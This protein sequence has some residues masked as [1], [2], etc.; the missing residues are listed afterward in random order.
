MKKLLITITLLFLYCNVQAEEKTPVSPSYL[1][2]KNQ[3]TL[4]DFH[5]PLLKREVRDNFGDTISVPTKL[6]PKGYLSLGFGGW[7]DHDTKGKPNANNEVNTTLDLTYHPYGREENFLGGRPFIGFG[8]IF[9]NSRFGQTD[10]VSI[11]NEW[12]L[13]NGKYLGFSLG[14]GFTHLRYEDAVAKIGKKKF[15]EGTLPLVYASLD[16]QEVPISIRVI[17]LGK[18][19]V[20]CYLLLNF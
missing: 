18:D 8:R 14:A 6:K 9:K 13:I 3:L 5:V 7:S 16:F 12:S 1:L 2:A 20:F 15:L 4:E 10:Y 19:I 17:P 11:G